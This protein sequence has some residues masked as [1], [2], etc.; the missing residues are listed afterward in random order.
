MK[1]H[2]TTPADKPSVC[3]SPSPTPSPL[4]SSRREHVVDEAAAS[5][6]DARRLHWVLPSGFALAPPTPGAFP[7]SSLPPSRAHAIFRRMQT[8]QK[9]FLRLSLFC[10]VS[11]AVISYTSNHFSALMI[12]ALIRF[13]SNFNEHLNFISL[14][15]C[16]LFIYLYLILFK[17]ITEF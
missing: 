8:F 7:P 6:V 4:S 3:S 13:F 12:L 16:L 1:Q 15:I 17:L 10:F 14:F 5:A 2:H 9:H 11:F